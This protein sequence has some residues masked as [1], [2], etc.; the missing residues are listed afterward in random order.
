M[1]RI[2]GHLDLDYFYAQVEEVENPSLKDKPVLV[3]VFSGRTDESGVVSTSN[4]KAREYGVKSGMPIALAK[5]RLHGVDGAFIRMDHEKYQAYSDRVMETLRS[6]VDVLEQAGIDEAFFDVT[7]KTGGDYAAATALALE[8]KDNIFREEKLTCSVGIGPNKVVAKIA[9]DL[10]KP[11]GLTV[12]RTNEVQAFLSPLPIDRIYGIGPKTTK[13]LEE[14]GITT[15]PDLANAPTERLEDL[16]GKKLA[17]YLHAAS[18]GVDEEP[19]V[20]RGG[21]SQ[22]SR[23]I[24]LKHDTHDLDQ[25]VTELLPPLRDVHE[26]L[27]SKNL[28][29]RNVSAMGI[30]KD[31]SIHTRSKTLETPTNDYS[32]LEKEVRELF[33]AL[34][35]EVGD[36]RRAGVRLSELLDMVDQRSLTEFTG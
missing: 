14:N 33:A 30:L 1:S 23:M 15:I 28:F 6:R 16:F 19:V 7:K 4:Y 24:T 10:K 27:V 11:N 18:S 2:V 26:K 32:I 31:L 8:L 5:R 22:L 20:E 36:L 13:L 29:F 35:R 3:C 12:V 34:L 21:A 9:S 25:I 17:V